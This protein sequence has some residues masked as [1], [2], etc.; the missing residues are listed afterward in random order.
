M[1]IIYI[2]AHNII[3]AGCA[4]FMNPAV[5]RTLHMGMWKWGHCDRQLPSTPRP[6]SCCQGAS[7]HFLSAQVLSSTAADAGQ[8]LEV[9]MMS[10]CCATCQAPRS[11]CP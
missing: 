10:C 1:A 5:E 11:G 4:R 6:K 8:A 2:K 3:I 7:R 9:A